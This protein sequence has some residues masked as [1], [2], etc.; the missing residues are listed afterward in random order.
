MLCWVRGGEIECSVALL[1]HNTIIRIIGVMDR[2]L[3]TAEVL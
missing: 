2:R 1:P 3:W